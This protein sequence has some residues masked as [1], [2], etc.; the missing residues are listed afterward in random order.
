MWEMFDSTGSLAIDG[1]PWCRGLFGFRCSTTS[2]FV[3]E[4]ALSTTN[5]TAL[6]KHANAYDRPIVVVEDGIGDLD[7]NSARNL[8]L[9]ANYQTYYR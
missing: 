6:Q 4:S 3:P 7:G 5:S 8:Q 1:M 9:R 2:G